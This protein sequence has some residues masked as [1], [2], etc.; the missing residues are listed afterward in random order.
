MSTLSSH[1][2]F[3]CGYDGPIESAPYDEAV[4]CPKCNGFFV[5]RFYAGKYRQMIKATPSNDS[6]EQQIKS[7]LAA[8]DISYIGHA[9]KEDE[10]TI[11]LTRKDIT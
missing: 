9:V 6:A 5:D 7:L 4:P 10:Y 8:Y 2:C 3:S 11:C 1:I